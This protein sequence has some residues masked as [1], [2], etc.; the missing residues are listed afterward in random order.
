MSSQ[1]NKFLPPNGHFMA[2][3]S[4]GTPVLVTL[5]HQS[6]SNLLHGTEQHDTFHDNGAAIHFYEPKRQQLH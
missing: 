1:R 2:T 5:P 4:R 6:R 3:T